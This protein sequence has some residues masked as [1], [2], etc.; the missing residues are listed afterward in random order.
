M[1]SQAIVAAELRVAQSRSNLRDSLRRLRTGLSQPSSLVAAL[2]VGVLLGVIAS[3]TPPA[4][5]LPRK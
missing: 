5:A 3:K 4:P 1:S 2:A